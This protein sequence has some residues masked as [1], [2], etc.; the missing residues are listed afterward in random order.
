MYRSY[1]LL[2]LDFLCYRLNSN[3]LGVYSYMCV[4]KMN[5]IYLFIYMIIYEI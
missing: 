1:T 3:E 4:H 5:E 2:G